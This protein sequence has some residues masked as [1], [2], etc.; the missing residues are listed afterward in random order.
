M[1]VKKII[2]QVEHI[3]GRQS[4][5]YI[6]QLIN[7][8]LLDISSTKQHLLEEKTMH[9]VEYKR[10]YEL[11]DDLIDIVR[12]EIKDTNDRY[13]MIPKMSDPHRLSKGDEY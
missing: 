5:G 1:K 4:E 3:F 2:E 8:A 11:D 6:F 12:V 13:A 10:W 9:L 7:D